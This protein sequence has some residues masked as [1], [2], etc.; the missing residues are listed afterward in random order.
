MAS[1][2]RGPFRPEDPRA[3]EPREDGH[4]CP[5]CLSR[6]EW[7]PREYEMGY[8]SCPPAGATTGMESS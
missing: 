1:Q 8:W 7:V 2:L 5:H 3:S 6:M 4:Y